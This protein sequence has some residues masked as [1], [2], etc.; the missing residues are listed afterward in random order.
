MGNEV[1]VVRN[2]NTYCPSPDG[3]KDTKLLDDV[4]IVV[5]KNDIVGLV[6]E[7]GSGKS[8]LINSIGH[9]L[10]PPLCSEA[11]DLW[12][13]LDR[14]TEHLLLLNEEMLRK[15]WGRGI[16]FIPS[17]ARSKLNPF[18]TIGNQ[19]SDT[20]QANSKMSRKEAEEKVIK[21]LEI[22]QVADP[23]RRFHAYP[24]ELSGGMS[25]RVV[26]AIALYLSPKLLLA[27]EPT[28][29]LDVTIQAQVLDLMT[30]LIDRFN[31]SALIATRD[32]GI[33]AHY[34]NK[35]AVLCGGQIIE[36]RGVHDFFEN[37][38]HPYSHYLLEAAFA[39]HAKVDSR[40]V[41]VARTRDGIESGHESGC[42]YAIRCAYVCEECWS[43]NPV[44]S[45]LALHY[46]LR[47]HKHGL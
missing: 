32:L 7:T 43:T 18:L 2:L 34:C 21:M 6:G 29:G 13:R 37:A 31:A 22:V 44:E 38:L 17:F 1:L 46:Y 25:Q 26:I 36:F 14:S 45:P 23:K 19:F 28:M 33:V 9:N 11:E 40:G 15:V 10:E 24:H 47:C 42:R 35:V 27:D 4:S 39:S 3:K 8:V 16:A 30:N 20:V 12:I 41:R 5:E